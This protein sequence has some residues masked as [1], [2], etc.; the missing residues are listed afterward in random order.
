MLDTRTRPPRPID[1][2]VARL[3][4]HHAT[5][6]LLDREAVATVSLDAVAALRLALIAWEIRTA[7]ARE[8]AA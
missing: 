8:V 5:A 1:A 3:V 6:A 7:L 2:A 4:D